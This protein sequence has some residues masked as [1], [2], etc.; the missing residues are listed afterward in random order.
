M[1]V[2]HKD[3]PRTLRAERSIAFR[4]PFHRNRGD[5]QAFWLV[6]GAVE[7]TLADRERAGLVV[8]R[9][10]AFRQLEKELRANLMDPRDYDTHLATVRRRILGA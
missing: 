9:A 1:P 4:R 7:Q 2:S 6:V 3:Q 5:M 10:K 8:D